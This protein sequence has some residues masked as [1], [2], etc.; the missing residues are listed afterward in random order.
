MG[1]AVE[2]AQTVKEIFPD[3][4][5]RIYAATHGFYGPQDTIIFEQDC[6]SLD[7]REAY[8]VEKFATPE[9]SS[10]YNEFNETTE[11]GGYQEVWVL[12]EKID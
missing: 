5:G 6:E 10:W 11:V 8:W 9:F 3:W 2:L 4:K 7:E 1:K 12:I